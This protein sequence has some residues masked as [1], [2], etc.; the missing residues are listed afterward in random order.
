MNS[1]LE[2]LENLST[3]ANS[4]MKLKKHLVR[5]V[6]DGYK[7]PQGDSHEGVDKNGLAAAAG[8]TRQVLYPK[9]GAAETI[10]LF[11]WAVKNIGVESESD[12]EERAFNSSN[13]DANIL[14]TILQ[15]KEKEIE[16]LKKENFHLETQN[17]SLINQVHVLKD[18]NEQNQASEKALIDGFEVIPWINE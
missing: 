13:P 12:Q 9:R 16:K 14:Q 4:A 7:L 17:Y 18:L 5:L 15:K 10:E 8:F 3:Q 1:E 11:Q 6:E 2:Y